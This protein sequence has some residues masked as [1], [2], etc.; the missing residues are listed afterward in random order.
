MT[1]LPTDLY[2]P[3][4]MRVRLLHYLA[5]GGGIA[6][7]AILHF[8]GPSSRPSG[9]IGLLL[10]GAINLMSPWT[11]VPRALSWARWERALVVAAPL[12]GAFQVS[13]VSFAQIDTFRS[14]LTAAM[15]VLLLWLSLR[16]RRMWKEFSLDE[17]GQS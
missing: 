12:L 16:A 14:V 11:Y 5:L 15:L 3:L 8:G 2:K 17:V 9:P 6:L 13:R 1:Q 4:W 10:F 7:L